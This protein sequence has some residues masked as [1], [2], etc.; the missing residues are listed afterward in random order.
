MHQLMDLDL[1][2][3][4]RFY[5]VWDPVQL[6]AILEAAKDLHADVIVMGSHSKRWKLLY[7]NLQKSGSIQP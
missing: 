7:R 3:A 1:A 6:V 4:P 5:T 2:Y